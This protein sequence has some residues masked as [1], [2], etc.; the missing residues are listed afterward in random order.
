VSSY[1]F[2]LSFATCPTLRGW[3]RKYEGFDVGMSSILAA[4]RASR[5][6]G[7][8]GTAARRLVM[9]DVFNLCDDDSESTAQLT[10]LFDLPAEVLENILVL[11]LRLDK[12]SPRSARVAKAWAIGISDA[13][14]SFAG[15]GHRW[16]SSPWPPIQP[17]AD[18]SKLSVND[19][20]SL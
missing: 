9:P 10:F 7:R 11:L 19:W 20:H 5:G 1:I 16:W 3:Q 18:L 4:G 6:V 14:S 15:S 13:L 8:S 2:H 17:H 12:K